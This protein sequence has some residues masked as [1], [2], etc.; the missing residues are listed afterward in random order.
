MKSERRI[1]EPTTQDLLPGQ[2]DRLWSDGSLRPVYPGQ[3]H[4][5][6]AL[7]WESDFGG[8]SGSWLFVELTLEV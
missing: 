2:G 8:R 3:W 4:S 1:C 7:V 6:G 5:P